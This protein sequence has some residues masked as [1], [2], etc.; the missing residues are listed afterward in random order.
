MRYSIIVINGLIR[1]L[2]ALLTFIFLMCSAGRRKG[3]RGIR[4]NSLDKNTLDLY[5][6][7]MTVVLVFLVNT[8]PFYMYND[9][10]QAVCICAIILLAA[11]FILAFCMTLA[12]RLKLGKWWENT[13]IYRILKF[14]VRAARYLCRLAGMLVGNIPLLWKAVLIFL[15]YI[16]VN[17][18]LM[19][20]WASSVALRFSCSRLFL[21]SG[22]HGDMSSG[23]SA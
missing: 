7:I 16:F 11:L 9:V 12:V 10:F 6:A 23:A 22:A 17:G 20:F 21:R 5:A 4:L 15:A 2:L 19:I 3:K 13:V 14:I 1:S 18:M 8:N